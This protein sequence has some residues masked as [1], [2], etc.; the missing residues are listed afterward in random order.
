MAAVISSEPYKFAFIHAEAKYAFVLSSIH[1][2]KRHITV[3]ICGLP[4]NAEYSSGPTRGKKDLGVEIAMW[5]P[6]MTPIEEF[7][8][9]G[10]FSKNYRL[11]GGV[12]YAPR[13]WNC[14]NNR[15][16]E[17]PLFV[18]KRFRLNVILIVDQIR[19]LFPRGNVDGESEKFLQ[20]WF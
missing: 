7:R 15:L 18:R 14:V 10:R 11:T 16:V 3:P 1:V 17:S 8:R 13:L 6:G 9:A 5:Q 4:L 12:C 19:W 20:P 2:E